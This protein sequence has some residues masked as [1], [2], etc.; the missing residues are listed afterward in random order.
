MLIALTY[1]YNTQNN[2]KLSSVLIVD[3]SSTL[4]PS[5]LSLTSIHATTDA[6]SRRQ[7]FNIRDMKKGFGYQI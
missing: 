3:F 1:M 6:P 5:P 7:V 4:L 2:V